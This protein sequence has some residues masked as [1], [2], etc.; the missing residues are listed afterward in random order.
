MKK[1]QKTSKP[2]AE[3]KELILNKIISKKYNEFDNFLKGLDFK[4]FSHNIT[5]QE[6][7]QAA[8]KNALISLKLYTNNAED[9]YFEYMQYKKENPALKIE[10]KEI[11]RSSFWMATGSGKT[12]VMIKLISILSELILKNKIPKKSIMLLAP[13]DKILTQ[14]KSQIQNFNNFN[15]RNITIR[16][17]KDFEK[18]D[19]EGNIFN[20]CLLYIARSDLIET[21]ENVG[22]DNKAKRINYKNFLQKEGWYILLD[23]AHKGDSKDSVRKS[24]FNTLARGFK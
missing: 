9:L 11:N 1:Q 3:Q 18:R 13:N 10:R 8:I 22:K 17:L 7:Q 16:E 4:T 12:I 24:Y 15:E 21:E 20:D 6:Y 19:F 14:F 23:E 5:L 2:T